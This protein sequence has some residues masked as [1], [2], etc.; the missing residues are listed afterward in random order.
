MS[1]RTLTRTES[2]PV[3]FD[4]TLRSLVR[5]QAIKLSLPF[6]RGPDPA[7]LWRENPFPLSAFD[8]LKWLHS[9]CFLCAP[10]QWGSREQGAGGREWRRFH[11]QQYLR[12]KRKDAMLLVIVHSN[13]I[14]SFRDVCFKRIQDTKRLLLKHTWEKRT[15]E[16]SLSHMRFN[17]LSTA[18][19]RNISL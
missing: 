8:Y 17:P 9:P 2:E 6:R 5:P 11:P 7:F 15:S 14:S 3:V 12:G 18:N 4:N 1:A 16:L 10:S 19:I 13:L